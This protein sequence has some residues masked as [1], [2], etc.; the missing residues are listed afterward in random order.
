MLFFFFDFSKKGIIDSRVI[1]INY[2]YIP[3][4]W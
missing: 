1:N 2:Q 4:F 3:K